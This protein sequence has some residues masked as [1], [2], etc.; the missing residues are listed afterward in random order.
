MVKKNIKIVNNI[1]SY[2]K[3]RYCTK[4]TRKN[5]IWKVSP[6]M[7][8]KIIIYRVFLK[9]TNIISFCVFIF[10]KNCKSSIGFT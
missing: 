5:R 3:N 4:K 10:F 2:V 1:E 7:E 8:N 6:L 9:V